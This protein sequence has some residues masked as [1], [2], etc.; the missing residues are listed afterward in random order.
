M[1]EIK[2]NCGTSAALTKCLFFII[3]WPFFHSRGWQT[4]LD[5]S[6]GCFTRVGQLEEG[7][8]VTACST[9][10]YSCSPVHLYVSQKSRFKIVGAIHA[11]CFTKNM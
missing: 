8:N 3:I 6:L 4:C 9:E 7:E 5:N 11:T 2:F 10:S 1:F